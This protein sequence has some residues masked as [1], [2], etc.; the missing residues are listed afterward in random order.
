VE[1]LSPLG[2]KHINLHGRYS[3]SVPEPILRGEQRPL[4]D[5]NELEL[6]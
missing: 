2:F 3:F 5:P 4:R 1:R 6:V